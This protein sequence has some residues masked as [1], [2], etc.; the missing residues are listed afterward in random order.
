VSAQSRL[1]DLQYIILFYA[2]TVRRRR[3]RERER[4]RG[5]EGVF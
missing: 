2:S 4:E 1:F 5:R 3:E